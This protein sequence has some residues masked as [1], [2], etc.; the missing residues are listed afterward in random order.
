MHTI[1]PHLLRRTVKVAVVGCGG[2]GSAVISG[3]PHLHQALLAY[4]HPSGLSITVLDGYRISPTNCVRQPFSAS[5]IGLFKSVVLINRLN[6]FW[7]LEWEAAPHHVSASHDLRNDFDLVIGCVDSRAARAKIHET[8]TGSWCGI[9]YWLDI[10]NNADSGQFVL[11]QPLNRLNK[12]RAHRLRACQERNVSSSGQ[13]A[14][15]PVAMKRVSPELEF[16]HLLVGN[17]QPGRISIGV[18]LAF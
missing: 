16:G 5:E 15:V 8:V 4:G 7:G 3:L 17:L 2:T 9:P 11:G 12:H 1:L 18:E 14:V 6:L 10:G 13:E